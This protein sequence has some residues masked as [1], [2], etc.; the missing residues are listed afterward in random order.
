MCQQLKALAVLLEDRNSVLASPVQWLTTLESVWN[1]SF[2]ASEGSCK[3][4]ATT[5]RLL[6]AGSGDHILVPVVCG[7]HFTD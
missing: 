3:Y 1:S 5:Q 2:K 4:P 7:E 6:D